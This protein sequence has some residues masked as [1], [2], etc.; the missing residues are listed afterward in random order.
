MRSVV[1]TMII[2]IFTV[3]ANELT[4]D[5]EKM[6]VK[7][8]SPQDVDTYTLLDSTTKPSDC[9]PSS[10]AVEIEVLLHECGTVRTYNDTH[11]TYSNTLIGEK[12]EPSNLVSRGYMLKVLVECTY[13]RLVYMVQPDDNSLSVATWES[14]TAVHE[15]EDEGT[16]TFT[17]EAFEEFDGTNLGSKLSPP[18]ELFFR[19]KIYFQVS[20][21][22]PAGLSLTVEI[23]HIVARDTSDIEGVADN[24]YYIVQDGCVQDS[25]YEVVTPSGPN[26][27]DKSFAVEAFN[28]I[29]DPD[30]A[31][32][33]HGYMKLCDEDASDYNTCKDIC[34]TRKKREANNDSN[35]EKDF[36]VY[37]G[38]FIWENPQGEKEILSDAM[39]PRTSAMIKTLLFPFL[40]LLLLR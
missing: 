32:Y 40:M 17:L 39:T 24:E 38:P 10:S 26:K 30:M 25:T 36:H 20:V 2:V 16:F 18:V 9:T 31:V 21:N 12:T 37:S 33:I 11:V 5:K 28:F 6:T 29:S 3:K 35:K 23:V 1:F 13:L 7:F 34:S 4:C 19:Q 14:G 22:T 27:I 8:D 15:L